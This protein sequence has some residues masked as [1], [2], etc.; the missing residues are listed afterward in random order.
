MSH[1]K[2]ICIDF[3]RCFIPGKF[4]LTCY[5]NDYVQKAQD[6]SL[7]P[8]SQD[9]L[10]RVCESLQ[11]HVPGNILDIGCNS[12]RPLDYV[13]NHFYAKG[14][15]VDVNLAGVHRAQQDFPQRTF[16]RY[17]GH[18]LPLED[19]SFDHVMIHHVLGHVDNPQLSISEAYRVLKPGGT[20]SII[21]PNAHFKLW[22][23]PF[24]I[25]NDFAPD[26]SVLRYY[27]QATFKN[28][29]EQHSFKIIEL[30]S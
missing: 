17:E 26:V 6:H 15:G 4:Q 16:Q 18:E 22:Q 3:M 2:E 10:Q 12:G 23:F 24:N 19:K 7:N 5:D 27:T 25:V 1:L 13:C 21:S 9:E 29:L 14:Q 28:I 30:K 20:L 8:A 11:K